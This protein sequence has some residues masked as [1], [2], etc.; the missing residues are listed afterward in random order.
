MPDKLLLDSVER[1]GVPASASPCSA[2]DLWEAFTGGG[3]PLRL[4]KLNDPNW[5]GTSL[6]EPSAEAPSPSVGSADQQSGADNDDD[7]ED[8]DED[9]DDEETGK[10]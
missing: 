1:H 9:G 3:N 4:P 5:F 2:S 8:D 10:T 6:L 7:I